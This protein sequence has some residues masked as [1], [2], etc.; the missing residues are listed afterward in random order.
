MNHHNKLIVVILDGLNAKTAFRHM[1]Y[2]SH[3]LE[4][5]QCAAY[6]V[7]AQLPAM[8]RPLYEVILTGTKALDNGIVNNHIVRNSH[9]Q[10]VFHLARA[11]GLS[12]GA[13]AYHWISELYNTSPFNPHTDR[14]QLHS[15]HAIE[16]G[17]F[18]WED[19]YPD[20]HL[21][22][23]GHYLINTLQTDFTLIHS[24]NIDDS[25]HQYGGESA[26]YAL[27]AAKADILLSDYLPV[28][29]QGGYQVVITADHGMNEMKFHGGGACDEE[30][31]VPLYVFSDKV[32]NGDFKDKEI[33]QLNMAPLLCYLSGIEKSTAMQKMEGVFLAAE[34]GKH[35]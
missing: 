11:Q 6:T 5:E 14:M 8:S 23:D 21:F 32:Q 3:L 20:N 19:D 34:R 24:M 29:L 17:I 31:L 4:N 1:G 35:E 28:W 2:L 30:R 26:H 7:R 10:S 16:H 13:A 9:Y 15:P 18:Y 25:G 27:K 22:A 33:C 12:T